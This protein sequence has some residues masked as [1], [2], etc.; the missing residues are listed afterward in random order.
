ME[1]DNTTARLI[2]NWRPT[3]LQF[4]QRGLPVETGNICI[5]AGDHTPV[6]RK[7]PA[8]RKQAATETQRQE[9]IPPLIIRLERLAAQRPRRDESV[10]NAG[11]REKQVMHSRSRAYTLTPAHDN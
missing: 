6:Y 11:F 9:A 10:A 2:S 5:V 7:T 8:R 3:S 4:T 1:L